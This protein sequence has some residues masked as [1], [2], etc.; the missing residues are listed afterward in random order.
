MVSNEEI[1]KYMK[2]KTGMEIGEFVLIARSKDGDD[3]KYFYSG[4]AIV[5]SGLVSWFNHFVNDAGFKTMYD[6]KF[7][8]N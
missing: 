2:E 4:S 8:M 6:S 1:K 5:L 3:M 7:P